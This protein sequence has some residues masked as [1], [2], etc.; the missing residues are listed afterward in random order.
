MTF[1]LSELKR[2]CNLVEGGIHVKLGL[3]I[4][5]IGTVTVGK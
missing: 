4:R 2:Y 1:V 3:I 5:Y